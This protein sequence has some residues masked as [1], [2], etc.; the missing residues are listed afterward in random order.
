MDA[1]E[2]REGERESRRRSSS[3]ATDRKAAGRR[4]TPTLPT[5]GRKK[6]KNPTPPKTEFTIL[7]GTASPPT[8]YGGYGGNAAEEAK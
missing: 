5:S 7:Y 4:P 1:D 3:S 2:G 8:S 6:K